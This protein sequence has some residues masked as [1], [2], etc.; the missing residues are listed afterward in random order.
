MKNYLK[1]LTAAVTCLLIIGLTYTGCKKAE[2]EKQSESTEIGQAGWGDVNNLLN[3]LENGSITMEEFIDQL[4]QAMAE[5]EGGIEDLPPG[6]RSMPDQAL[7]GIINSQKPDAFKVSM[8]LLQNELSETVAQAAAD[9]ELRKDL[10]AVEL[11][12]NTTPI[13]TLGISVSSTNVLVFD[14]MA[15]FASTMNTLDG[16]IEAD[17]DAW[18]NSIGFSSMRRH[19]NNMENAPGA[20]LDAIIDIR[21]ADLWFESVVNSNGRIQIS[22]TLY[23][24]DFVNDFAWITYPDGTAEQRDMDN[25]G[26]SECSGNKFECIGQQYV[27]KDGFTLRVRGKKQWAFYLFRRSIVGRTW[28][29]ILDPTTGTWK[30]NNLGTTHFYLDQW[31]FLDWKRC[32][33][34]DWRQDNNHKFS[35]NGWKC[36]FPFESQTGTRRYYVEEFGRLHHWID[37]DYWDHDC[38]TETWTQ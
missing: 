32:N 33:K 16:H 11:Q 34:N 19:F 28:G 25:M 12:P 27:N 29:Q 38:H 6:L 21:I 18:E 36:A 3:Q 2:L 5:L 35:A 9:A 20:D 15:V 8:L 23:D 24:F 13:N 4:A 14:N 31:H 37:D 17:L 10:L 7:I 30:Q 22:D 26:L 1:L